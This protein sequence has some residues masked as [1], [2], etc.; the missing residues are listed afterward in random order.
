MQITVTSFHKKFNDTEFNFQVEHKIVSLSSQLFALLKPSSLSEEGNTKFCSFVGTPEFQTL[1]IQAKRNRIFLYNNCNFGPLTSKTKQ[2]S[3]FQMV[4]SQKLQENR[5]GENLGKLSLQCTIHCACIISVSCLSNLVL[6]GLL[7]EE[8]Q[9]PSYHTARIHVPQHFF[10][11][12]RNLSG[13]SL[14]QVFPILSV[15]NRK[16]QALSSLQPSSPCLQT[17]STTLSGALWPK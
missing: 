14:N 5:T 11:S 9:P 1:Q 17:D 15:Q 10:M 3:L 2:Q 12:N 6:K 16:T 13:L 4:F 7:H 8:L